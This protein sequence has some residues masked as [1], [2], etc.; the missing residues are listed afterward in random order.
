MVEKFPGIPV[1]ARKWEYLERYYLS[2]KAFHRDELFHLNSTRN[3]R[4]FHS[5]GKRSKSLSRERVL[6][7]PAQLFVHLCVLTCDFE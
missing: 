5:N 3:Y 7:D 6:P 4:K 1:K 2:P